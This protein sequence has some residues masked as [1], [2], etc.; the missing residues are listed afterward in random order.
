MCKSSISAIRQIQYLKV[1]EF[2]YVM[3]GIIFQDKI[4]RETHFIATY[5]LEGKTSV[6]DAAWELAIGQSVGNPNVRNEWETDELSKST[7][8]K[9]REMRIL[10]AVSSVLS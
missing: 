2:I 3:A 7:R 6:R 10:C 4:D 1:K 8:A 9:S 5:E